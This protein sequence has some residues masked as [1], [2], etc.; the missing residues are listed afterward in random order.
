MPRFRSL[1]GRCRISGDA[2]SKPRPMSGKDEVIMMTQR[3]STG[4]MGKMERSSTS[5]NARP[6]RRMHALKEF[7]FSSFSVNGQSGQT[8]CA[9]F[10]ERR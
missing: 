7:C 9:I 10:C 8:H 5:L 3:I 2:T 6:M 1:G 4:E